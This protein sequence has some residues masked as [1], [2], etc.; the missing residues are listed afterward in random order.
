MNVLKTNLPLRLLLTAIGFLICFWLKAQ[1]IH[2]S[3]YYNSPLNIGPGMTGIFK[4]DYRFIGNYRKQWAS[5]PVDY[6]TFSGSFDMRYSHKKIEN[7]FFG[8]GILFN[9]D[10]AG[11]AELGLSQVMLSLSYSQIMNESNIITLGF[12]TGFGQRSFEPGNLQLG[13][14]FDGDIFLATNP[15]G[16]TFS[17]TSL[18]YTDISTGL[19]WHLQPDGGRSSLD[20]GFGLFHL[21]RPKQMFLDTGDEIELPMR[22]SIYSIGE[23][24]AGDNISYIIHAHGQGQGAWNEGLIGAGVKYWL[25]QLRGKEIAL[26]LGTAYRFV[27]PQDAVIPSIEVHY[28]AWKVGFSYDVNLSDFNRATN[29]EGGPELSIEYIITKVGPTKEIKACP[30]F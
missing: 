30:I 5:V 14:Q 26:Q 12:Q 6:R 16:E 15:T 4:G 1:D 11:D 28:L 13:N 22:Y 29:N 8:A 3:Q 7:G 19:N 2:F 23:I 25:S 10:K 17:N 24:A 18:S 20:A 27:G 21:N 9:T